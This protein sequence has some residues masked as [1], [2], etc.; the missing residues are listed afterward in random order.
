MIRVCLHVD[1]DIATIYPLV[2]RKNISCTFYD[3]PSLSRHTIPVKLS[4]MELLF[5]SSF[6][7]SLWIVS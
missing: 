6:I 3:I 7:R 5:N 1:R 2:L 4:Y